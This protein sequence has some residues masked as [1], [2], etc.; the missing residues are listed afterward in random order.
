MSACTTSTRSST[1]SGDTSTCREEAF[2]YPTPRR[3]QLYIIGGEF[4]R[5]VS[6]CHEEAASVRAAGQVK[7]RVLNEVRQHGK[8]SRF[9]VEQLIVAA[10]CQDRAAR[11]ET[12]TVTK[13]IQQLLDLATATG[14]T[15]LA[16]PTDSGAIVGIA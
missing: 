16:R 8:Y 14:R 5:D 10:L 3:S 15:P 6:I 11:W 13:H 4:A 12:D 9:I 2:D 7:D 1:P